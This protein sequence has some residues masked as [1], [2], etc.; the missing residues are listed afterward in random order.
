MNIDIEHLDFQMSFKKVRF[1]LLPKFLLNLM[2]LPSDVFFHMACSLTS[3]RGVGD[4]LPSP[5]RAVE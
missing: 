2:I 3:Q 5:K 1:W 4:E